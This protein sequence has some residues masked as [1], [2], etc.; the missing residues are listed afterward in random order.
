MTVF[1]NDTNSDHPNYKSNLSGQ[2]PDYFDGIRHR[3]D[4]SGSFVGT[5]IQEKTF[6]T[7]YTDSDLRSDIIE[8]KNVRVNPFTDL[9]IDLKFSVT[10]SYSVDPRIDKLDI[11]QSMCK[12]CHNPLQQ[13]ADQCRPSTIY[14]K[15]VYHFGNQ[16]RTFDDKYARDFDRQ[17]SQSLGL[18]HSQSL[19]TACYM[20]DFFAIEELQHYEGMKNSG[21]AVNGVS[22]AGFGVVGNMDFTGLHAVGTPVEIFIVNPNQMIYNPTAPTATTA[23]GNVVI[24]GGG[25]TRPSPA[26]GPRPG[27]TGPQRAN[28]G[29]SSN[30]GQNTGYGG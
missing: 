27:N 3:V 18:Y 12:V 17:Q 5:N 2:H 1:E 28:P 15:K 11:V 21:T 24:S 7:N 26:Y 30:T 25:T 8:F 6:I 22:L 14:S 9:T 19:E 4:R 13:I 16:Q 23:G 20:D 10:G 29:Q